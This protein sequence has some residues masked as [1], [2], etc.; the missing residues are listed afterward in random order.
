VCRPVEVRPVE[1][2]LAEERLGEDGCRGSHHAMRSRSSTPFPRI[3][4]WSSFAIQN[5]PAWI[6]PQSSSASRFTAGASGFLNLS[7]SFE[8]PDR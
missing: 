5:T 1:V 7:Q 8:R 6:Q 3:A 4:T 2:R